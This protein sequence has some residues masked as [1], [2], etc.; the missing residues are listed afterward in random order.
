MKTLDNGIEG[1]TLPPMQ[2][3]EDGLSEQSARAVLFILV[4]ALFMALSAMVLILGTKDETSAALTL[5]GSRGGI[6]VGSN[7]LPRSA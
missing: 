5:L 4:L 7:P 6:D 2:R 3:A 1:R